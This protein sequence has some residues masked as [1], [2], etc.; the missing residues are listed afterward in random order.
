M[1]KLL[2]PMSVLLLPT[3]CENNAVVSYSA[4]SAFCLNGTAATT[5]SA[6]SL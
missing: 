6:A 1:A 5:A 4:A 3:R 2:L